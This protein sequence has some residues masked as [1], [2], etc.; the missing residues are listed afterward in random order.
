MSPTRR[1]IFDVVVEFDHSNCLLG[2]ANY[3]ISSETD[4]E[5][6]KKKRLNQIYIELVCFTKLRKEI[7]F[8]LDKSS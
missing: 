5:G 6:E 7:K 4:R 3:S 2:K 8:N 1:L